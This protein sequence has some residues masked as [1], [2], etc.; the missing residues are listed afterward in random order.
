M[1]IAFITVVLIKNLKL[2]I[3]VYLAS[4]SGLYFKSYVNHK[5]N[6][7]HEFCRHLQQQQQCLQNISSSTK[8]FYTASYVFLFETQFLAGLK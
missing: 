4:L 2:S 6:G 3:I 7:N 8:Q 1:Y 5:K